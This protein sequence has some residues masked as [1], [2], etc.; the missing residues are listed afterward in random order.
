MINSLK[1]V[2]TATSVAQLVKNLPAMQETRV[3]SLDQEDPLEKGM[4]AHSSVLAWRIPWTEE[5]GGLQSM[6][7]QTARYDWVVDTVRSHT[8]SFI[9]ACVYL[10]VCLFLHAFICVCVYFGHSASSLLHWA[11]SCSREWDPLST[12]LRGLLTAVASL[13]AEH[14]LR[15]HGLQ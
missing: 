14:R 11:P 5:V 1:Q 10:C 15:E 9:Y 6:G 7:S 3:W 8:A 2:H 13:A 12:V 4:A